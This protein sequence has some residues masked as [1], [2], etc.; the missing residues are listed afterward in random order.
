MLSDH[1]AVTAA[2]TAHAGTQNASTLK[3]PK[4]PARR[5]SSG[6][7]LRIV[8]TP[9]RKVAVIKALTAGRSIASACRAGGIGRR[10]HYD[11]LLADTTYAANVADGHRSGARRCNGTFD[12]LV[13][14]K[15]A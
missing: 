13:E 4:S 10:T 11:W 1:N 12:F 14:G 6:V 7:A 8:R 9:K 3:R 5:G 2:E 15:A